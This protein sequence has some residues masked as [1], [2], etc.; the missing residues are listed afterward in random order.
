MDKYLCTV[1]NLNIDICVYIYREIREH[2]YICKYIC[3]YICI[4]TVTNLNTY[5]NV[6]VYIDT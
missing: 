3:I 5:I 6:Y 2:I 1:T 4:C